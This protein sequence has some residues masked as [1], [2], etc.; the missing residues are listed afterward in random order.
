MRA[1]FTNDELNQLAAACKPPITGDLLEAVRVHLVDGMKHT[2]AQAKT[3]VERRK[4]SA[5]CK[6]IIFMWRLQ[7]RE[8]SIRAG[9]LAI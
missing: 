4:I 3:G 9:K 8:Q 2:E 1:I 7:V 5:A 6:H